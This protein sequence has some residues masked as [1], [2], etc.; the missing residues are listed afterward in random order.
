MCYFVQKS[1]YIYIALITE[2]YECDEGE[3]T[4]PSTGYYYKTETNNG[5]DAEE[6]FSGG[7]GMVCNE[8]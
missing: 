5:N 4:M 6:I 7:E 2:R 8:V 3:L 1:I